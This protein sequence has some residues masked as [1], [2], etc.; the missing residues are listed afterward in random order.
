ML[1]PIL[2]AFA[3]AACST[4]TSAVDPPEQVDPLGD[5][6]EDSATAGWTSVGVGVEYQ[7]VNTGNAI[8]I[9]YGG[10]TAR[11]SYSAAWSTELVD[12]RLG[13]ANVGQIYAVKGPQDPGYNAREI[14]N[15]KLR[16]HLATIDDGVSPIYVVA[17]SSGA[18]VADELFRQLYNAGS[19]N[20]LSRISYACLDGGVDSL[21]DAIVDDLA[22]IQFVFAHDPTLSSGYSENHS[23]EVDLAQ[24]YAPKAT[25]F[26][27]LV[28][29][30]G[31]D[32]GAGWCL[33]DVLITHRPHNPDHFDLADDYTD[34]S[35][36]PVT[37]E[38][39]D[40]WLP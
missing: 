9:A 13:A 23:A 19:T 29:H 25:D 38:Y 7:R 14:G 28:S 10:Y 40:P 39:F 27:V 35:G 2:L 15:S 24:Q 21:P 30:T 16:R 1:R 6:K 26:E 32:D 11:M 33:H 4:G 22:R 17:H 37:I 8:L 36:R 3:L 12:Q 20:V 5:G 18:Y 34:F 31:C